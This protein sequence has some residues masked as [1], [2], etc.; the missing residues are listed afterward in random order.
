MDNKNNFPWKDLE[1]N[2]FTTSDNAPIFYHYQKALKKTKNTIVILLAWNMSPDV[3][4]PLLVTNKR[5]KKYYDVYIFVLKGYIEDVNYGNTIIRCT[6]DVREFIKSKKIEKMTILGHSIGCAVWWNYLMIYGSKNIYKFIMIDEMTRLLKNPDETKQS[7]LNYGSINFPCDIYTS[8]NIL[9]KE[10]ELSRQFRNNIIL[11]QFSENFK[12]SNPQIMKKILE[13]C[14]LYNLKSSAN[15]LFSNQAINWIE[16]LLN[17]K[18]DIPTYLF[19]GINSVVPYQ[20]IKYQKQF[21]N[22]SQI[23]IFSGSTSSH[24]A[25]LENYELFNKLLDEF[26]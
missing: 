25:F 20:S 1:L 17:K 22:N 19:G 16:S 4:S 2:R 24:F 18:I 15:I 13:K 12:L 21:Y 5:I 10:N 14:N 6:K 7:N 3:F 26:L 11:L 8:Y 23:Y 9:S